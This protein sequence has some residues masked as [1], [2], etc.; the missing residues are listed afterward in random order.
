MSMM[1]PPDLQSFVEAEVSSGRYESEQALV[2][3]AVHVLRDMSEQYQALYTEVEASI[4]QA[5]RGELHPLDTE[6][7]KAEGRRRLANRSVSS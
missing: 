6:G 5:D 3:D 4:A 2:Q 7:A 1:L